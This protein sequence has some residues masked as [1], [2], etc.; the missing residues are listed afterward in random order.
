MSGVNVRGKNTYV[1][2]A[3]VP[4]ERLKLNR[5]LNRKRQIRRIMEVEPLPGSDGKYR[6]FFRIEPGETVCTFSPPQAFRGKD[7]RP[8]KVTA[9]K[10]DSEHEAMLDIILGVA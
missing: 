7:L 9:I 5:P 2:R 4:V 1:Q 3:V 10:F 6:L 8:I